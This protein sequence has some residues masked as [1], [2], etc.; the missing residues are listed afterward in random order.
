MSLNCVIP[1]PLK[2][3]KKMKRNYAAQE[4]G[5]LRARIITLEGEVAGYRDQL[6]RARGLQ[7]SAQLKRYQ[8]ALQR[9]NGYLIMNKLEPVKLEYPATQ[10][11]DSYG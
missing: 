1:D 11:G 7:R 5:R 10:N 8:V 9:A 2:P 3:P 6:R 4:I